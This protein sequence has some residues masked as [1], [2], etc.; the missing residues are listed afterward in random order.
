MSIRY[1]HTVV[2][3][4][5][6]VAAKYGAKAVLTAPKKLMG[7]CTKINGDHNMNKDEVF[8]T[9]HAKRFIDMHRIPLSSGAH[10][11]RQMRRCFTERMRKTAVAS[12]KLGSI[13]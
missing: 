5:R 9:R 10:Y 12:C 13:W 3:H 6:K 2:H 4:I 1:M 11:A 8:S 7:L